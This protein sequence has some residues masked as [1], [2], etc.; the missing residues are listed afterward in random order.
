MTVFDAVFRGFWACFYY[1]LF[2]LLFL[3]KRKYGIL[4]LF[5]GFL[6]IF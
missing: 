6:R 4:T 2:F 5:R 3:S 1:T